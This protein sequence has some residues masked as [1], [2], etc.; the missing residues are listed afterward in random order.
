MTLKIKNCGMRSADAIAVAIDT[1][2]DFIGFLHYPPSSRYI[3]ISDVP[4]LVRDIPSYI[5]KVAVM[6]N[7]DDEQL[8]EAVESGYPTH[9]Q[10]HGD[11]SPERVEQIRSRIRLPI[12]KAVG[13]ANAN[14]LARSC[15]YADLVDYLLL[16]TKSPDYGGTGR[17]FDWSLLSDFRPD[18]P[19]FL[20]GGLNAD[21]IEEA[22]RITGAQMVDVSSGLESKK[23]VKSLKRIAEFNEKARE[24]YAT[25]AR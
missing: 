7:P 4:A 21:N 18:T 19:W 23:G 16:D 14:D 5:G 25:T 17:A 13:I 10:L 11:E 9:I 20:S 6:V 3:P 22:L 12:I 8:I 24:A 1:G 2:A 15:V